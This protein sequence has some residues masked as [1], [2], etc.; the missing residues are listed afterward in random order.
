[1]NFYTKVPNSEVARTLIKEMIKNI[2][3]TSGA[4]FAQ[5]DY[6]KEALEGKE[7]DRFILL[8]YDN[9]HLDI[10]HTNFT[11]YTGP[12]QEVSIEKMLGII[13]YLKEPPIVIGANEVIFSRDGVKVGCQFVP[14]ETILKIAKKFQ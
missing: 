3:H 13:D 14:K 5:K 9:R 7:I 11:E 12:F 8:S 1:M 2:P 4:G 10:R 6:P